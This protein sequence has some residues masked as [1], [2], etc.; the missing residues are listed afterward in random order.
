MGLQK[1]QITWLDS[2]GITS[3]WE[4][5]DELKPLEPNVITSIG[6]LLEDLPEYKTIAQSVS[7]HQVL[8]RTSI[9]TVSI[10]K[11]RKIK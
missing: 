1:V 11:I 2:K 8:G 10:K 6:Y 4:H 5:K 3:S 7:A 9:P